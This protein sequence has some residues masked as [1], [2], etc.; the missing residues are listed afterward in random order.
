MTNKNG[1]TV[2]AIAPQHHLSVF[3]GG[4]MHDQ[5]TTEAR[6]AAIVTPADPTLVAYN[7]FLDLRFDDLRDSISGVWDALESRPATPAEVDMLTRQVERLTYI[8][9][10]ARNRADA[11]VA[12]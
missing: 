8:A 5:S 1:A 6:D 4:A 7:E 12:A 9:G 10:L 3:T 11:K 2:E